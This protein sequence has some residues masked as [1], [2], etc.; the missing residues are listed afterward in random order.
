MR[1]LGGYQTMTSLAHKLGGPKTL[2]A[3]IFL[4]GVTVGILLCTTY[5]NSHMMNIEEE[6]NY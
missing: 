3:I 2:A 1:N 4:S 6:E 5:L